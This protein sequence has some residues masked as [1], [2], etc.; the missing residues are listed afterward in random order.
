MSCMMRVS[1]RVSKT[2]IFRTRTKMRIIPEKRKRWIK[3]YPQKKSMLIM[4]WSIYFFNYF[5]NILQKLQYPDL[6]TFSTHKSFFY[7]SG[8]SRIGLHACWTWCTCWCSLSFCDIVSTARTT[9]DAIGWY[10][11][12]LTD[13]ASF[14]IWT[15]FLPEFTWEGWTLGLGFSSWCESHHITKRRKNTDDNESF[16]QRNHRENIKK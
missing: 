3:R 5:A 8:M 4:L 7:T 15:D 13:I 12:R 6:E 11:S 2:Q 9:R 16:L 14:A 1:T 10:V